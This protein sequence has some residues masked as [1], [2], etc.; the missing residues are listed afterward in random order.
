MSTYNSHILVC[1]G[2]GCVSLESQKLLDNLKAVVEEKGYGK[3][4]QVVRTGCFGFCG[5]GPIVKILPDNTVYVRVTPEDAREVVEEHI[6]KGRQVDRLLYKGDGETVQDDHDM[7]FYK[8]QYRIA[9]YTK[10]RNG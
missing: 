8:K 10:Y 3:E 5:E 4:T 1:G 7:E 2:T 6:I 9:C